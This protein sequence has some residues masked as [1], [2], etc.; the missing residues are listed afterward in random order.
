M[1]RLAAAP[2][3]DFIEL[4]CAQAGAVSRAQALEDG[5]TP[6]QIETMVAA[7]RWQKHLP[8]VYLTF[9]GPVPPM[10]RVWGALLYAGDG[11]TASLGTAAWL[12]G[13]RSDLPVRIDVCVPLGRR[14][15]GQPGVRVASRSAPGGQPTPR[16]PAGT[17]ARRGHGARPHRPDPG[18][19]RGCC[20]PHRG[21][22]AAASDG[23][24]VGGG[25]ASPEAVTLAR[26]GRRS[27][28]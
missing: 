4:T 18:R 8:G 11:A 23:G 25:S 28:Q 5:L 15:F 22:S 16:A 27:T 24:A 1:P 19:R 17:Y 20:P 3:S 13:L 12:W 7:R 26:S 14:V 2:S 10:T 21:V 9:T 6:G